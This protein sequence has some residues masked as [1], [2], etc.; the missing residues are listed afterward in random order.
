MRFIFFLITYYL[1]SSL[2][3]LAPSDA[4][5]KLQEGNRRFVSGKALGCF[6]KQEDRRK[7]LMDNQKPFAIILGCSD[8]RV[9]PEIL[10]DQGIGD[11]FIIRVAG[12]VL[13]S[14]E[15]DSITYA[16]KALGCPLLIVLGHENCGAVNAVWKKQADMIPF[17]KKEIIPSLDYNNPQCT[18]SCQIKNNVNHIVDALNTAP[19]FQKEIS[20]GALKVLGAFYP[21]IS[22]QVEFLEKK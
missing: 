22:G 7:A 11:L 19:Q 2:C 15:I 3:A 8:S 20:E 17:I 14:S 21:F 5:Q 18:L 4:L 13:G 9:P 6:N 12:N 16:V 1:V 10:F